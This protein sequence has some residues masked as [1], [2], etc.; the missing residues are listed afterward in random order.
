VKA[1]VFIA[2]SV[3]GFIARAN[4]DLDWLPAGGGEEH[5]YEAFIASVDALVIGRK[6]FET[7]LTFD[8]WPY[9]EKPV[10]VLSTRALAATPPGAVVERM[11]GS[12]ADIVSQLTARGVRHAY[13][14]GGITIQQFLRAGL[15]QRLIITRVP[16]LLGA[17]IPLFGATERD[18]LLTHVGTRQYASGLVQSEYSVAVQATSAVEAPV[19][20]SRAEPFEKR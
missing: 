5:G 14:D 17:G 19:G 6:T 16:V 15:I 12:P 9:G 4:G 7:V 8:T 10:Y 20:R 13:V 3:D 11:S 18:I 2:T 1:S